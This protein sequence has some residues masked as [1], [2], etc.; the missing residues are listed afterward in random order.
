MVGQVKDL[1]ITDDTAPPDNP[2]Y[3][4][5]ADQVNAI[6]TLMA[7]VTNAITDPINHQNVSRTDK[8][9]GYIYSCQ[10][11]VSSLTTLV[12]IMTTAINSG[13]LSAVTRTEPTNNVYHV[14]GEEEETIYAIQYARDLAKQAIVN[15]LP[16]TDITI[17]VDLGGCSDVKSTIDTLSEIVWGGID[18]PSSIPDRNPGYYPE[19]AESTPITGLDAGT[20]YFIIRVNDNQFKL[21]STKAMLLV[22]LLYHLLDCLPLV[23]TL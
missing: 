10:N 6:T 14:G 17:T 9:G 7:I 5:C 19:I 4:K 3:V 21:A 1:T 18:N 11:V 20:D 8:T 13:T 2:N 12:N 23:S 15:Q 16:F 22:A